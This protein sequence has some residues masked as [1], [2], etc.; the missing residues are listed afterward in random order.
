MKK[1]KKCP[2]CRAKN[3][4]E[5]VVCVKCSKVL[6]KK[7][8]IKFF[9]KRT[10]LLT[11][12]LACLVG[13]FFITKT[14][15]KHLPKKEP[16][17]NEYHDKVAD[18][19]GFLQV[20]DNIKYSSEYLENK[21]IPVKDDKAGDLKYKLIDKDGNI[22]YSDFSKYVTDY[23]SFHIISKYIDNKNTYYIV[24]N[25]GLELYSSSEKIYYFP[26]TNS[27]VIGGVLYHDKKVISNNIIINDDNYYDGYYFSYNDGNSAG[28]IDYNGKITFTAGKKDYFLLETSNISKDEDRDYCLINDNYQYIIIDCATGEE[29][30]KAES[31]KII[32]I[33]PNIFKNEGTTFYINKLGK[34]VYDQI[35]SYLSDDVH[36]EYLRNKYLIIGNSLYNR[37]T[38]NFSQFSPQG[39]ESY[40]DAHI[41]SRFGVHKLYCKNTNI[42]YGLEYG[43]NMLIDCNKDNVFYLSYNI[44]D[45]LFNNDKL[46]VFIQNNKRV[47]LYDVKA[48]KIMIDSLI[49]ES[50]DSIFVT[51]KENDTKYIYNLYDNTRLEYNEGV[52]VDIYSNYF[53]LEKIDVTTRSLK[54]EYYNKEFVKI[55]TGV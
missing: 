7:A 34:V 36:V 27:W 54:K 51:Y 19:A 25:N 17:K 55:F 29:V 31:S 37:K 22:K 20:M 5:N 16:T 40:D 43:F 45:Y 26:I 28:I 53:V 11:I 46:Y 42:Y 44:M 52:L 24:D 6:N 18:E 49:S 3:D 23:N 4:I 39:I 14:V 1:Y 50:I 12:I 47:S 2:Y 35:A 48:S 21:L 15:L 33:K 9:I 32:Q 13:A 8:E 38:Y 10:I 41:E 30:Y